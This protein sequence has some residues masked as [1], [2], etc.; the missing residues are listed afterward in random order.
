MNDVVLFFQ[1]Y[2]NVIYFILGIGILIYGWRFWNTWQELRLAIYG[3]ERTI[4]QDRLKNTA[5]LISALLLIGFFVFSLV[6]FVA[7][8][9]KERV[10]LPV[11]TPNLFPRETPEEQSTPDEAIDLDIVA[12][13]TTLPTVSVITEG[14]IEG[15]IEITFPQPGD[16]I[17]GVVTITGTANI[18]DF[19]FY[20]FEVAKASEELWL[21]VQAGRTVVID[22][23]LVKNWDTSLFNPGEYVIQ[24][25]VTD[26]NGE[27]LE[28]C[29]VPIVIGSPPEE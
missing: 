1:T 4:A 10:E 6:T 26:N 16:A 14:C 12:T 15:S 25:V 20:K 28:P 13:A 7:P 21:T 3:L 2:E 23:D 27:A 24:L 29:R 11:P 9:I 17:A 19:G 8:Y 22:G 5:F 18:P